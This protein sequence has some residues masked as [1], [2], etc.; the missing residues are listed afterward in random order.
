MYHICSDGS[1]FGDVNGWYHPLP[2]PERRIWQYIDEIKK[3][4]NWDYSRNKELYN[5]YN[6]NQR[7]MHYS[8]NGSSGGDGIIFSELFT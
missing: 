7:I 3:S 6:D 8:Y 1:C 2:Q 5:T 4:K